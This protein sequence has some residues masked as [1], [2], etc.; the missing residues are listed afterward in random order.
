MGNKCEGCGK[1][2]SRD[3][4]HCGKCAR[5][6]GGYRSNMAAEL[7]NAERERAAAKAAATAAKASEERAAKAK[8][9]ADRVAAAKAA[10]QKKRQNRDE[11]KRVAALK[12]HRA[13]S[14]TVQSRRGQKDANLKP[15]KPA[16]KG[17]W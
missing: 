15:E 12:A 13:M 7:A 8:K 10:D 5:A 3:A 4:S 6:G 14:N 16:K 2:V 17:W 1:R 11:D 9:I